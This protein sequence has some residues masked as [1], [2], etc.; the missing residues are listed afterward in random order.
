MFM[1]EERNRRVAGPL[2]IFEWDFDFLTVSWREKNEED[3]PSLI[4]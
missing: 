2:Y 1:Y 3:F 4:I